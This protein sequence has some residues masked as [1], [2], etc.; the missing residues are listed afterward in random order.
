MIETLIVIGGVI[1]SAIVGLFVFSRDTK[2]WSNRIYAVM[3]LSFIV[4]MIANL[5]TSGQSLDESVV[6]WCIRVVCA[7][8]TIGLTSLYFL[9]QT[10]A[11][12]SGRQHA[13]RLFNRVLLGVSLGVALLD[14]TPLVFQAIAINSDGTFSVAAS[15]GVALFALHAIATV[16]LTVAYL[17]FGLKKQ[18]KKVRYQ[19]LCVL[20]GIMPAI[21][22]APLTS[23]VLPVLYDTTWS[24]VLSPLYIVFFTVMVAYAMIRHGLFDIRLAAVRSAA[25]VLTLLSLAAI[26]VAVVYVVSVVF[27][28]GQVGGTETLL[29]PIAIGATLFI[30]LVF[31]PVKKLFDKLTDKLFYRD[32]YSTSQFIAQLT[33]TLNSTNDLRTL[34]QR[35]AAVLSSTFKVSQAFFFVNLYE[36]R[37]IIAGTK[38]HA[39][40]SPVDFNGN[41]ALSDKNNDIFLASS[42]E[43]DGSL[44]R[45]MVSHRVELIMV[46]RKNNAPVGYVCLGEPKTAGFTSRDL[47]ALRTVADELTIAIQNAQSVE[48]VRKL[49]DTLEQRIDAATK[50][51][52][53]SNAQLQR[54]DEA[55]DEF[56]SMASHQLRTPLTGI[57]GYLSMLIEGDVGKVT[58][59]QKHL[60]SEAFMSSERMV[61]LIGDFLNVSRLQTGKFVIDKH[62]VDLALLVQHELDGLALNAASR[63][64]TFTYKK[65]KNIPLLELDEGKIQ[66]V[67]MNF[68][69]NAMY[70]SKEGA[71]IAVSL[72][73]TA[74]GVEF[75]VKDKGIGVPTGEQKN[76]FNKFF[77]ATNARRAR[78]DGTGVGLFLAKKVIISHG[79]EIIF[80]SKEGKG[81]TFG[82]RLPL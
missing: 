15:W 26:Y 68:A 52:R 65:P 3:T 38:R 30:A 80:E 62:P 67:V 28:R 4:L 42:L 47:R 9:M 79:G 66:Q 27:F 71:A 45:M 34:L 64:M 12:E 40:V 39:R 32:N 72:K 49:N 82:F 55:K 10:L 51:L 31:Q 74:N 24:V 36:G 25:Y 75:T 57:K 14:F 43:K 73:K 1:V 6:L 61:R 2:K 81:S 16:T 48:E 63:G 18:L 5:F 11:V 35:A 7:A 44:R 53:S 69:D 70:Y 23:F 50:E 20:A 76:L 59:E 22:L 33:Q 19:N 46:L 29:S 78:P 17:L 54:L 8:T 21:V 60:L 56:I 58:P 41:E 13:S 77:R 37:Y